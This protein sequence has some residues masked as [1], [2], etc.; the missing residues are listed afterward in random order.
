[1]VIVKKVL[2]LSTERKLAPYNLVFSNKIVQVDN[3]PHTQTQLDYSYTL[4]LSHSNSIS[5]LSLETII[6]L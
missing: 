3:L 2:K 6:T 1:M 4:Q 5:I